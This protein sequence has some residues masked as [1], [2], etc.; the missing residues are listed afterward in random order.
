MCFW[1]E[2]VKL[3]INS[4]LSLM[5]DNTSELFGGDI[6]NKVIVIQPNKI[7]KSSFVYDY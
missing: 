6:Q 7:L 2:Y 3:I 4:H 5:K 1:Q